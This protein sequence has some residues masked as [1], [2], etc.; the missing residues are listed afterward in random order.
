MTLLLDFENMEFLMREE[1][2]GSKDDASTVSN[3]A[4]RCVTTFWMKNHWRTDT[5]TSPA[6]PAGQKAAIV[7]IYQVIPI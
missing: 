5:R 3:Y 7:W 1:T 2:F 4:I 6:A